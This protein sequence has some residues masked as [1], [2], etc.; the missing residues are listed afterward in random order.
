VINLNVERSFELSVVLLLGKPSLAM[1]HVWLGNVRVE[2]F[3][4]IKKPI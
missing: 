4:A 1:K 2:N 3:N